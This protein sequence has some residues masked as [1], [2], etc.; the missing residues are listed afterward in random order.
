MNGQTFS[1][2]PRRRGKSHHCNLCVSFCDLHFDCTH[3]LSLYLSCLCFDFFDSLFL[4]SWVNFVPGGVLIKFCC[5]KYFKKDCWKCCV[6]WAGCRWKPPLWWLVTSQAPWRSPFAPVRSSPACC[7]PSQPPSSSSSTLKTTMPHSFQRLW[8]RSVSVTGV[9]GSDAEGTG[10][11]IYR[12]VA[13]ILVQI[14]RGSL[15][16][17]P[18]CPTDDLIGQELKWTEL[19]PNQRL[20]TLSLLAFYWL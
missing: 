2:N 12:L 11:G 4:V 9:V 10:L 6:M 5:K 13:W 18:S 15:L 19:G 7:L 3:L 17:C 1:K 20:F 8:N 14:G 16:D